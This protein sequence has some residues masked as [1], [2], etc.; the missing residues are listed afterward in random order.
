M[1]RLRKCKTCLGL[2][3]AALVGML[4]R[5]YD[6]LRNSNEWCN[7]GVGQL[8]RSLV[9]EDRQGNWAVRSAQLK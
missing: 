9:H 7:G 1:L 4:Y 2:T 5:A 8:F 3:L 6:S